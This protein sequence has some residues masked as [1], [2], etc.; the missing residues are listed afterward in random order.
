[1]K[2]MSLLTLEH[3]DPKAVPP[4]KP[5]EE[6]KELPDKELYGAVVER[7]KKMYDTPVDHEGKIILRFF[8]KEQRLL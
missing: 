5:P 3:I 7:L 6:E 2:H 8:E 1:M 4:E